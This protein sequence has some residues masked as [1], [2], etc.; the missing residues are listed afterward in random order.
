MRTKRRTT[1]R[2][3]MD[4]RARMERDLGLQM[5][6]K[7]GRAYESQGDF[8]NLGLKAGG[9]FIEGKALPQAFKCSGCGALVIEDH[10]GKGFENCGAISCG[11]LRFV[12]EFWLCRECV[13]KALRIFPSI[14]GMLAAMHG[15]DLKRG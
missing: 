10:W 5:N 4:G 13:L 7:T 14:K 11:S 15:G 9:R 1:A 8:H 12:A 2:S 3:G 6:P